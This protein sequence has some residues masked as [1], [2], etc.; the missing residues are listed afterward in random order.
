MRNL[1]G[2]HIKSVI[3]YLQVYFGAD[4]AIP[5]IRSIIPARGLYKAKTSLG[6]F[7]ETAK[8]LGYDQIGLSAG[9]ID[10]PHLIP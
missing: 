2:R 8:R 5:S 7:C 9:Y 4:P 10:S 3:L 6:S 1:R